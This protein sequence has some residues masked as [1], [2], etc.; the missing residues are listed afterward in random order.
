MNDTSKLG[1]V[2][3]ESGPGCRLRNYSLG[4]WE[5]FVQVTCLAGGVWFAVRNKS[6]GARAMREQERFLRALGMSVKF[7]SR[8]VRFSQVM[9]LI[10]GSV[11]AVGS[12]LGL[13]QVI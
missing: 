2:N 5:T 11:L 3:G 6:L 7:G 13:L 1:R 4:F 9:F 10:V 12:V 8:E